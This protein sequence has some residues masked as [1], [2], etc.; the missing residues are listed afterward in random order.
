MYAFPLQIGAITVGALDLYR[1]KPMPIQPA[2]LTAMLSVADI[3]TMVLL[4]RP[5][6]IDGDT[7]AMNSWWTPSP[8]SSEIHQATGM[9]V[10]QLSVTARIAYLRLRAYAFTQDRPLIE[11][12]REVIGRRLRFESDE[13]PWSEPVD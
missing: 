13:E 6:P 2:D 4:S 12:A 10:A 5:Q 11:V 9:V 8:A 1:T 7:G 3:V